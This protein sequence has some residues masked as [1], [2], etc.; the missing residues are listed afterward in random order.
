MLFSMAKKKRRTVPR[1]VPEDPDSDIEDRDEALQPDL[2]EAQQN[3]KVSGEARAAR[4][5]DSTFHGRKAKLAHLIDHLPQALWDAFLADA[6]Q[7]R[8]EAISERG[9][10]ASLLLGLLVRGLFT[11]R[12]A[13]PLGLHDQPVYTDIPV[14]QAAIPDLSCRN[15]FLQL[16]R[17]LPG[18]GANTQPNAAVAA[19]LAAHPD[20]RARLAAIPRHLSDSNMVDHVGK[21]L[22]TAFSNILTLLFAGRLKKSV[23][24]AG[25]KRECTYVRRMVCGLDVSWLLEQGGVVPAPAMQAEVALQRGLLGLEEGERVDD[26]WVE[27]P[28]N[29]GRLLRHAVH[30][31]REM[32]AAMAAWQLDMVPWQQ[33]ELTNPGLLPRP[34]RPPTPYALTPTSKC[35]AR[36]VFIDTRGLYGMMHD[37]GMLGVLTDEGVTSLKKFR[38]GALPDPAVPGNFI[39]GPKDSH[40]ANRWDAL[41]PDPRRQKLASPKHNFAQIVHTDGVAIS[42]MF[43]RPKPAAPPAEL[44]RM[45]RGL[46]AVN[47]LAHLHAEWLGVDPGKTN[48]ATVAHEERSAAGTVVSVRH[49][50][51]TAGQYYRD[52]GI[53]RQAQATKTWLAKVKPQLTALSRVSSKPSSLASYRRFANTV[54]ATYDAMW[55]EVSKKRWANAKFRLYCGKMRVV[56][57]FWAK[58]KKQAQKRWPDRILA[59]A[60][61]AAS[62]SGSGSIGCR[63]VPV[64][65]MRKEAVKQFGAGR[66]VLVDEFRT[67]R[68]SSAYSHPIEALPG[69][70]PE[71]FRWLRPVYSSAKRSQ[72]RGLMC[73]TSNNIRF[74][75]RDVS[76]ALNIRRCAVGPGPRPTELCY[77]DGR[78]AMPKPGRPGQEW[79]YLRDKA[80][81]RKWRRKTQPPQQQYQN[82]RPWPGTGSGLRQYPG[83]PADR[84]PLRSHQ[85]EESEH[86]FETE[87]GSLAGRKR[88]F[89]EVQEPADVPEERVGS[90]NADLVLPIERLPL[91]GETL[92]AA[93]LETVPGGKA[94]GNC[95]YVA[96]CVLHVG[97]DANGVMLREALKS[98]GVDTTFLRQVPGSSGTA[99]ILLQQSG[100]NSIIIVGGANQGSW[101]LGPEAQ[102]AIAGAGALLL[103]REVP[104]HVN[105]QAAQ[106]AKTAGV[107]VYLDAGGVD[108]PLAPDLLACLTLLSPNETELA[109]L[110]HLRTDTEEEIQAAAQKLQ[111]QGVTSVLVKLGAQ[112]SLLLPGAGQAAVR[113]PAL[114]APQVVDTT[115]AGDCFTA[116]YAVAALEGKPA[117]EALRFASAAGCICV[118][119]SGA[120]PSLPSRGEHA[121]KTLATWPA[122][123]AELSKPRWSNARF[124]LYGGKQRMVAT[125]GAEPM[126]SAGFSGSGIIGSSDVPVNQMLR[127]ACKQF[128]GRVVMVHEFR[129]TRVSS[130]RTNTPRT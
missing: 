8:V 114:P 39:A 84:L 103:Q 48:M 65:Q 43:L 54:L 71:S 68:V 90:V 7:P 107:P 30:T 66:V 67:S 45:G 46:D 6:V 56:A 123:W 21:Q 81:L 98:A 115:G 91:P 87:R 16:V 94:S 100:E 102:A 55:A 4:D 20:L 126:G 18:N 60:Y 64:S 63:G 28:V 10:L 89:Q 9:V 111:A 36:H 52:S 128:P 33:A 24:L 25:A 119:R 112:G 42:V 122:M 116:A 17:G 40:V 58:V 14:S 32:E 83:S 62:F 106:L 23:S 78:P 86:N 2:T 1:P 92:A 22:E 29:R 19:V 101:E 5:R 73:S 77:W 124:Q 38:N 34:P 99:L 59:L 53:T 97:C 127:E 85:Q 76:A 27:D 57:S 96:Q 37:A 80:L 70:P 88:R 95:L 129:T 61:G 125:F 109:R 3:R 108:A 35:R 72:V 13:D 12:V 69:Q 44:P 120:Q 82:Q 11:I 41:L 75:D 117:A 105:I 51:L 110:T 49:W 26:D 118:Q 113:Q 93:S 31:T 50:K 79:V 74:Y 47:P 121:A 130:A 15:L 104:E